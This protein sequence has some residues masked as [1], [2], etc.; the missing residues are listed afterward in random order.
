MQGGSGL[1]SMGE[2]GSAVRSKGGLNRPE[3]NFTE[4]N[5]DFNI[6]NQHPILLGRFPWGTQD[7]VLKEILL[8]PNHPSSCN[9][10]T[11][12]FKAPFLAW[13]GHMFATIRILGTAFMAGSLGIFS[14]PPTYTRDQIRAMTLSELSIFDFSEF[15]PKSLTSITMELQDYRPEHFH[16]G[17]LDET[18]SRSFGGWLYLV[19]LGRL[20]VSPNVDSASI[21]ILVMTRG[22]Y[23]MRRPAPV[24]R[25]VIPDS[26]PLN[27]SLLMGIRDWRG[28]DDG[29]SARGR[30]R[31]MITEQLTVGN[32]GFFA[33]LP[34]KD[35]NSDWRPAGGKTN[36]S[37]SAFP[38]EASATAFTDSVEAAQRQFSAWLD[39]ELGDLESSELQFQSN[40]ALTEG[41]VYTV[42]TDKWKPVN[43]SKSCACTNSGKAALNNRQVEVFG[44]MKIA[45][46][47][48]N[49]WRVQLLSDTK[50]PDTSIWC[51][52]VKSEQ[53]YTP[54]NFLTNDLH[55]QTKPLRGGEQLV[56]ISTNSGASNSLQ[57][58]EMSIDIAKYGTA[59]PGGSSAIYTLMRDGIDVVGYLRIRSDGTLSIRS[60][61]AA[62][63]FI[64][65]ALALRWYQWL[66]DSSQ[67]PESTVLTTIHYDA[68][69]AA[70]QQQVA[71]LN[72]QLRRNANIQAVRATSYE[73]F[74]PGPSAV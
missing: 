7:Q 34:G 60:A 29:L 62:P 11:A 33:S 18:D 54:E 43:P 49:G 20:N 9:W 3:T 42:T 72:K 19:V 27:L 35:P 65:G 66:P 31:L 71:N 5:E 2:T 46:Q 44:D 24:P 61:V 8:I 38:N 21:D 13:C 41:W 45:K 48:T 57:S 52:F 32:G 23:T 40:E 67:M 69:L 17:N 59:W 36:A 15:D 53:G 63:T 30:T 6:P 14:I 55:Q 12:Y 68:Q 39:G 56:L 51:P 22:N 47:A 74:L 1:T 50:P 70:L 64:P 10:L 37:S 25:G 4:N 28:C 73:P 26:G 16:S 58:Y